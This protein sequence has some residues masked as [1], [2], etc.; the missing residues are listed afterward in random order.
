MPC[1]TIKR[2]VTPEVRKVEIED[3]LKRL[4]DALTR[5]QVK[6]VIGSNG[7]VALNG[8]TAES[9]DMVT[10]VCAVRRLLGKGSWPLRQAIAKAEALG[11]RKMNIQAVASGIH[12]HDGGITW[13]SGH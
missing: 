5:G 12:S 10:D 9:R 8:W 2:N 6:V 1:D 13:N 7:A 4:E 3:A 11:G